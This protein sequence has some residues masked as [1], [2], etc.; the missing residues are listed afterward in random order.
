MKFKLLA[1]AIML[2]VLG[3]CYVVVEDNSGSTTPSSSD[4]GLSVQ[5]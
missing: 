2:A 4:P 5:P 1:T 3:L